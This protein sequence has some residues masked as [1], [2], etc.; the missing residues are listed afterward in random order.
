MTTIAKP[1]V[2]LLALSIFAF[3]IPPQH[4][5]DRPYVRTRVLG[6]FTVGKDHPM[7]IRVRITHVHLG[8][9]APDWPDSDT[10]LVVLDSSGRRLYRQSAYTTLGGAETKFGCSQVHIPTVGNV[11]MR[12]TDISPVDGIDGESFQFFG[13]NS[14]REFVSLAPAVT[15]FKHK[16]VFLDSRTRRKPVAADSSLPYAKPAIEVERWT[17]Y[18][19]AKMYYHI[20]PEGFSRGKHRRFFHFDEIPVSIEPGEVTRWRQESNE[21]D[22]HISLFPR[23]AEDSSLVRHITVKSNSIIKYF[24]ASYVHGWWLFLSID[25]HKGYISESDCPKLGFPET[26]ATPVMLGDDY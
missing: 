17:G 13:I 8:R 21:G 20:Y 14:K 12:S 7:T 25:G 2:L 26:S 15:G 22:A 5:A 4:R 10:L 19:L 16:I 24:Y 9:D 3:F 23:P 18:Y 11:L 1:R 6:P